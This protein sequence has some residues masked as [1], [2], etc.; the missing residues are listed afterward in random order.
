[1]KTVKRWLRQKLAHQDLQSRFQKRIYPGVSRTTVSKHVL[2]VILKKT[3]SSQC[4]G[5]KMKGNV[6]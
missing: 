2:A 3:S 6:M 5:I 1:M 4:T